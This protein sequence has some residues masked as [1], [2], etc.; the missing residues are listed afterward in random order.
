M[1]L[2]FLFSA[3]FIFWRTTK[4]WS[5]HDNA[6]LPAESAVIPRPVY[7]VNENLPGIMSCPFFIAVHNIFKNTVLIV[8]I[9]RNFF[10]TCTTFFVNADTIP[11]SRFYRCFLLFPN[12]C[13]RIGLADADN[14]I[15][16]ITDSVIIHVFL[17]SVEFP[18][19]KIAVY[20]VFRK[21]IA[22]LHIVFKVPQITPDIAKLFSNR[23]AQFLFRALSGLYICKILISGNFPIGSGLIRHMESHTKIINHNL[24][25]L[26]RFIEKQIILM[27][28]Y[29]RRWTG[30]IKN[31]CSE[32]FNIT[33]CNICGNCIAVFLFCFLPINNS[34]YVKK[35]AL[36][37]FHQV[38]D[39]QTFAKARKSRW[40]NQRFATKSLPAKEILQ[41]GAF[42]NLPYH[43]PVRK[44]PAPLN[45]EC[46]KSRS[47]W[48]R[49][50]FL[51]VRKHFCVLCFQP[52]PWDG[53]SQ[54]NPLIVRIEYMFLSIRTYSLFQLWF[55]LAVH[56]HI[57]VLK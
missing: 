13:R 5:G 12:I 18:N 11:C 32:I 31:F 52:S 27:I 19:C 1:I 2:L 45:N 38:I 17:L 24:K 16:H 37:C 56:P 7:L 14:A 4:L 26:S 21:R 47:E 20:I 6:I 53:M 43:R 48:K 22:F 42:P 34:V 15:L 30:G 9:N 49:Q 57:C 29:I 51:S 35:N 55:L 10:K 40:L 8:R 50:I 23:G 33:E 28:L 3:V 39:S 41:R 46:A 54:L 36:I 25:F 44:L